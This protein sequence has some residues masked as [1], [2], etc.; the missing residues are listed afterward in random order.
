MLDERR[1]RR[2]VRARFA[3]L[4][5]LVEYA[6]R[7][8]LAELD[9]PLVERI[10]APDRA[11]HVDLVLVEGDQRAERLRGELLEHDRVGRPVP[12]EALVG[13]EA[14]QGFA[15]EPLALELHAHL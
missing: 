11:L 3:R 10:D 15:R 9:A 2:I 14:L 1:S 5:K 8:L 6:L 13:H 12:R 4:G 7:E